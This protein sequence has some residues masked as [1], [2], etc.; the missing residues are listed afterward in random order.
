MRQDFNNIFRIEQSEWRD[1]LKIVYNEHTPLL[2]TATRDP[3]N[4]GEQNFVVNFEVLEF[5]DFGGVGGVN[6]WDGYDVSDIQVTF[7]IFAVF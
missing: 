2:L 5:I 1:D 4:N 7:I 6:I 3:N